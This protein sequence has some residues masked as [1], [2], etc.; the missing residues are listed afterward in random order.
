MLPK[1]IDLSSYIDYALLDPA[2]SDEQVD[3]A[4]EQ[5]D[6]FSFASLCVYPCNVK[7][8]TERLLKSKVEICTVIGFPSGATTSNVKLYEAM[9]AVENGAT[10]LDVVINFGWLK[11][12]QT[13]LLH[14]DIA[15]IC[16]ESGKPVKA[17]L[18][19][20][21]LTPDEQELAAEVCMDAGVAFL[22]TG[23]GWA[24]GATVEMVKFLKEISRGKVGVKASGG[25]RTRE[26]AIA[27]LNAGAN[28]LGTSHG[29]AIAREKN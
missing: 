7:R 23:T 12:G 13:N 14:Q 15:Q 27:L 10:E 24:G 17:I 26:Q 28:R 21:L 8:A 1:D 2:A 20:S 29:T 16:E 3:Y 22:K 4:C 9:E 5:A 6:R 11:T 18:E 25:I 19:L